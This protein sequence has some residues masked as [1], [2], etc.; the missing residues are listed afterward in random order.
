MTLH[1]LVHALVA[2]CLAA[3]ASAYA[4]EPHPGPAHGRVTTVAA[5][6]GGDHVLVHRGRL[7]LS[8]GTTLTQTTL[9]G[10]EAQVVASG[11]VYAAC[12]V[13]DRHGNLYVVD[14]GANLVLRQRPNGAQDVI[15]SGLL[16]PVGC[17]LDARQRLY[18]AEAGMGNVPGTRILRFNAQGVLAPWVDL[19]GS[20]A[21]L[22]ALSGL[23]VDEDDRIYV[24]NY[25]DGRIARIHPDGTVSLF[26]DVG[27]TPAPGA[28]A[29][30]Y[31]SFS[32]DDLYATHLSGNR[33]FRITPAG[34]ASVA[35]GTGAAG[36]ADGP[37]AT[38]T[39]NLPN[40]VAGLPGERGVYITEAGSGSLRA[41]V[42]HR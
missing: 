7:L 35:A 36:S 13:I 23:A 33:L 19:A 29:L 6:V 17:A 9:R 27:I 18:V 32:G 25:V 38:A 15:A 39:F 42:S 4:D 28:F 37:A 12:K 40:G 30:S 16:G 34:V 21:P 11:F 26:A 24:A 14:F 2:L 22:I 8:T 41:F 5:G 31:L 1:P 3:S 20:A 10:T